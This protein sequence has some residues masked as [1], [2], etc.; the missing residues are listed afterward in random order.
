MPCFENDWDVDTVHTWP[1]STC[2]VTVAV[3]PFAF[4]GTAPLPETVHAGMH[5]PQGPADPD[6]A[7]SA[8]PFTVQFHVAFAEPPKKANLLP[9][10]VKFHENVDCALASGMM[11]RMM[12]RT[13][14][15]PIIALFT[16]FN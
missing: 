16:R 9:W 5:A 12:L 14:T 3:M 15:N 2:A 13:E 8:T 4:V 11:D 10:H 6:P 7:F 1:L